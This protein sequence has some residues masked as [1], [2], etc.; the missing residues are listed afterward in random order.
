MPDSRD[1]RDWDKHIAEKF[2]K[3][4]SQPSSSSRDLARAG[5]VLPPDSPGEIMP[6]L[7][8]E[9]RGLLARFKA[10]QIS[11]AY[12][13]QHLKEI[14]DGRIEMVRIQ[15][16]LAVK[17]GTAAAKE[18]CD[19]FLTQLAN[20][21]MKWI[22]ELGLE[23][24]ERY[25]ELTANLQDITHRDVEN[26]KAK[27]WSDLLKEQAIDRIMEM[28]AQFAAKLAEAALDQEKQGK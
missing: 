6:S 26:V 11:R 12:A 3:Q 9:P 21:H 1:K 10:G 27:P 4:K 25:N 19:K 15:V 8:A 18:N 13:V 2:G 24:I 7:P 16:K 28:N 5:E 14:A 20:E 23:N 17:A 22:G